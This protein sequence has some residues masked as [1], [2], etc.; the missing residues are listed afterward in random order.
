MVNNPFVGPRPFEREDSDLFFGRSQEA[1]EL[2]SLIVA[3]RAVVLY[4]PSGAGKTSLLN[5]LVVPLL[6]KEGGL[7]VYP[8]ARVRGPALA[9]VNLANIS[10][11]YV[12]YTLL[13]W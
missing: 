13:S 9:G 5:A 1:N 12:F 2:L 7:Q 3:N 11:I 6:E 4:A 10:N 8:F